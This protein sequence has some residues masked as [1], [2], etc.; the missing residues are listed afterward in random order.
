MTCFRIILCGTLLLLAT[1][2]RSVVSAEEEQALARVQYFETH[3]R[4]LLVEHCQKCHGEKVQKGGLRL[5][6]RTH[7]NKGGETGPAVVPGKADESELILAVRYGQD[8]YQMPPSGKLPDEAIAR[9]TE[10][11]NQGAVWPDSPEGTPTDQEKLVELQKSHWSLQPIADPAI[12]GVSNPDRA[13]HPVDAFLLARLDAAGLKPSA[14]ASKEVLLRRIY[15]DLTGLPPTPAQREAFLKDDSPEAWSRLIDQLLANPAYG[16]RWAR[17]WL[18][19]VRYAETMGHEFDFTIDYAWR[20][21]DYVIRALNDDLPFDQFALEQIAG[22]QLESARFNPETGLNESVLG[23]AIYWLGQGKHSP[24]DVRAEQ[25]DLIDNQIDVITKAFLGTSVACARCHDHKFDPISIRD[26]YALSG[27]MESSRKAYVDLRSA[28]KVEAARKRLQELKSNHREEIIAYTLERM[29]QELDLLLQRELEQAANPASQIPASSPFLAWKQLSGSA[30]AADFIRRKDAL[31]VQAEK[32]QNEAAVEREGANVFVDFRQG[33][34]AAWKQ[35]GFA[36][37]DAA[38]QIDLL[39]GTDPW[40]PL[41]QLIAPGIVHSG[42][43]SRQATGT[44]FSPAFT[45][46]A[47]YIDYLMQRTDGDRLV[48]KRHGGQLKNG[49]V[50]LIIDGFQHARSPI[51]G[52]VSFQSPSSETLIWRRQDVSKWVGHRAYLEFEDEDRGWL[53]IQEIRFSNG[54]VPKIGILSGLGPFLQTI[55]GETL[56]DLQQ[57][58]RNTVLGAL[59]KLAA[60]S[61]AGSLTEFELA[62][63]NQLL[64]HRDPTDMSKSRPAWLDEYYVARKQA[65]GDWGVPELGLA[66]I[67]GS[68]LDSPLLVRGNS[69]RPA[70][71]IPRNAPG[72]FCVVETDIPATSSG[73]LQ[74]AREII[75]PENT[76]FDRVIVNRIWKQH[77]GRGLVPTPDDLGRMGVPPSHPL[78]LDHLAS[79]FRRHNRSLKWLHRYLL[80]TQTYQMSSDDRPDCHEID[81]QNRLYHRMSVRRLEAEALRDAMLLVSG[82]LDQKLYGPPVATYLTPFMTGRGRPGASGPLNGDNRRSLYLEVRRNFLSPMF[83]AFDYPLPLTTA[84]RRSVSNVPAQALVM[85]N[86]EFA[87]LEADLWASQLLQQHPDDQ[88]QRLQAAYLSAFCREPAEIEAQ[89]AQQFF[90]NESTTGLSPKDAWR[91]Y[92]HVLLNTK[93]FVFVR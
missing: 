82:Q 58:Y 28:E 6:S 83:L 91:D 79:E 14:P 33:M 90:Q 71:E 80:T 39:I 35:T 60:G 55:S 16:E 46:T 92:C 69:G 63:V 23:T 68:P 61:E 25:C 11:V 50:N 44:L 40:H 29:E 3:V 34:S 43:E 37:G 93:E 7:L 57:A 22:D 5:D 86:S 17:H 27:V 70:E 66:T 15:F 26:Y 36:F 52:D 53:A 88:N 12:P 76:L 32:D 77:F 87:Y 42:R 24:V 41:E 21:R 1:G 72:M 18:D 13:R 20:Y 54:P 62:L 84:G 73:R 49:N 10:W 8:G 74:F 45:I 47:P 85:L 30:D 38:S 4:P 59:K 75:A 9:L 31:L 81:P 64:K 2:E 89:L 19:L 67:E 48:G 56:A 51:Y 78:L 65:E